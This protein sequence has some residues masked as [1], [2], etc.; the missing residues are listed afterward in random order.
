[1]TQADE[2]IVPLELPKK[3]I[4]EYRR[5]AKAEGLTGSEVV[6]WCL[7]YGFRAYATGDRPSAAKD[8]PHLP[9]EPCTTQGNPDI[10]HRGFP[11]VR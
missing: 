2:E 6:A 7:G 11:Y 5:I 9:G 3:S 8:E 4:Q 10:R 1:M